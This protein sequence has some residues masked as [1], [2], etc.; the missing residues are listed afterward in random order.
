MSS[1]DNGYVTADYLKKV[2]ERIRAFKQLSY[3]HMAIAR[4]DTVLDLGCGPGMDTVQLAALVGDQGR[5][6]VKS[7]SKDGKELS[8]QYA[9]RRLL[10]RVV[11]RCTL[12]IPRSLH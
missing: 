8:L 11:C 9:A 5:V 10:T 6:I 1:L 2:A 7:Y 4:G 12:D 3:E